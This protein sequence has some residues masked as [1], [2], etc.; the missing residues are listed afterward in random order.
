MITQSNLI[1]IGVRIVTNNIKKMVNKI[2]QFKED[3]QTRD[4][5]RDSNDAVIELEVD[6]KVIGEKETATSPN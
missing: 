1:I 2:N 5:K 4:P 6:I 3:A